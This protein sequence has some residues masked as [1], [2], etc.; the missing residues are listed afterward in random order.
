M[1]ASQVPIPTNDDDDDDD[2][3]SDDDELT[4]ES[5]DFDAWKIHERLDSRAHNAARIRLFNPRTGIVS[6][7]T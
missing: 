7:P 5:S 4:V 6:S 1:H 2:D 3:D